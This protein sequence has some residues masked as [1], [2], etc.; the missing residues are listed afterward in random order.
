MKPVPENKRIIATYVR[1]LEKNGMCPN[2]VEL[3]KAGVS[4]DKIRHHFGNLDA[5]K[6]AA[7]DAAPKAFEKIIDEELFTPKNFRRL[8]STASQF[9]RFVVT[10]AVTGCE[11]HEGFYESIKTYCKLNNA[12]LLIL[13]ASD[14]AAI[15]NNNFFLDP[16]LKDE[17]IVFDDLG[18]NKKLFLS[19]VKLSAKHIDPVTSFSRVGQ[20]NGSFIYASPKQRLKLTPTSNKKLPHA[21]MTTGA[22]TKPDYKSKRYMSDRTAYLADHDHVMGAIIVEILNEKRFHFRQ[23]Q[24]NRFG[25]FADIGI[26]YTPNTGK[27]YPPDSIALGDLHSGETDATAKARFITDKDSVVAVTGT[28]RGIVHDGFNG[29]SINHHELRNLVLRAQLARD[30]KID[31]LSELK[32]YAA[33]LDELTEIFDETVIDESNHDEFLIRY[34]AEGTFLKEPHNSA[35]GAKLYQAAIEGHNPVRFA[36]EQVVGLE[37][38]EKIR[39]LS[40]DEDFKV[41]GIELGAH[42]DKGANG[43]RGS[44]RAM[45]NAY[46][47]SVSGHAHTPEIL[48]GAWQVGTLSKLKLEYNIG[49]SSWMHTSCLVYP[50][51]MRQLINVIDGQWRL[52]DGAYSIK[53]VD[54]KSESSSESES[55]STD[56]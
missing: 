33:D 25:H 49:P 2:R 12:G 39:W 7:K 16:I 19:S 53:S 43:A 34:L 38:P 9:R 55:D 50:N 29:K 31:L 28:R 15:A 3:K 14:P 48:R 35:I 6:A 45:E 36:L 26:L 10:T 37:H 11:V 18:L 47:N 40:R 42:G 46:G 8:V 44:L 4:R 23:V 20:R 52:E 13:Y 17:M 22:L 5:L 32:G 21:V 54:G 41:A 1:L 51:G 30:C 27:L 56:T 24:A